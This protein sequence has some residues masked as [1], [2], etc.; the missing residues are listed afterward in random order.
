M[1]GNSFSIGLRV[2]S[3]IFYRDPTGDE[4]LGGRTR[5]GTYPDAGLILDAAGNLY[6]TT[7]ADS[8]PANCPAEGW[9]TVFELTR[10]TSRAW[11]EK[12]LWGFDVSDGYT[13]SSA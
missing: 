2:A 5:V 10:N 12:E 13:P 3:A 11:T 1:R 4:Y 8:H 6:G 9:G 7:S